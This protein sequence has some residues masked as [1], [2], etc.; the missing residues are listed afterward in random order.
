VQTLAQA[1][2][3]LAQRHSPRRR[4]KN[5]DHHLQTQAHEESNVLKQRVKSLLGAARLLASSLHSGL[6]CV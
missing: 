2:P 4:S 1:S 6:S 5:L 3:R